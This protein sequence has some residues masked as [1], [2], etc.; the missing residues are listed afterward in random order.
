MKDE[1]LRREIKSSHIRGHWFEY[2]M[3]R[4]FEKHSP[5]A[6]GVNVW[7]GASRERH[8][9]SMSRGNSRSSPEMLNVQRG[10][11]G[12]LQSMAEGLDR[13]PEALYIKQTQWRGES[14]R[15]KVGKFRGGCSEKVGEAAAVVMEGVERGQE[16]RQS[17]DSWFYVRPLISNKTCSSYKL[18][19][20]V[21]VIIS[22]HTS[23]LFKAH[24][25][26]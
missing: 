5:G 17:H 12:H 4:S 13:T 9:W 6:G 20:V 16:R 15:A 7:C 3:K 21:V 8:F 23:R 19:G 25:N 14:E 22:T 11:A 1:N 24:T 18:S 2:N 26:R 10:R